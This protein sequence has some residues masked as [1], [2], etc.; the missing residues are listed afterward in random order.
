M[1]Q[2]ERKAEKPRFG[3]LLLEYGIINDRQLNDALRRQSQVGGYIGSILEEMGFLD[4]NSLSGFLSK[5]FNVPSVNLF[6]TTIDPDVLKRIPFEKAREFKVL[7]VK[8]IGDKKIVLAMVNPHNMAVI[9]ELEFAFGM[10]IDPVVVPSYQMEKA[11]KNFAKEGYGDKPFEGEKLRARVA[12]TESKVPTIY[13][14]LKLVIENNASDL[15]V[16]AGVPPSLRIDNEIKRLSM[17]AITPELMKAFANSILTTEQRET[18]ERNKEIDFALSLKGAGRF[19][20]NIYKQRNSISMAARYVIEE[21]PS[22]EDLGIPKWM[23]DYAL[24]AQ[25]FILITGPSGHGKTTTMTSLI[26]IINSN[27]KCNI[28]TLEDPIEFLHKHKKSN[29][30]QRE[31]GIDTESF[32]Q[33]L[34]HIFRQ[35]PDVIVIGEIRD[36]ESVAI[37]LT[38]AETGHL[39]ISTLHSLNATTA[40][41]RIIDLFPGYQQYQV[42]MQFAEVFLLVFAQRLVPKKGGEG[43]VL[44]Y[45]KMA[46]TFRVR[47]LIREGKTHNIRSFMQIASDDVIS[48]DQSLAKLCAEGKISLEDGLKFADNPSYYEEMV[49]V[50]SKKINKKIKV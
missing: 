37:G 14:L 36:P 42:R 1:N 2:K 5:Q 31:V 12:L 11:I 9:E 22:P 23:S 27:R 8:T 32:A 19:R 41:D 49:E 40:V 34:K 43:R 3:E 30:N 25:G 13:S 17:P 26:E 39:V 15:H 46:N 44:A 29:I 33:G 21:I 20:V 28:V 38:A 24:K 4:E 6:E 10:I 18:F 45:E 16:T 7:P 35:D 47:N 50:G 48:I